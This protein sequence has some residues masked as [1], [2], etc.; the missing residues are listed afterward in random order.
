M[1]ML[2]KDNEDREK[3]ITRMNYLL[4]SDSSSSSDSSSDSTSSS[5]SAS[6]YNIKEI[7]HFTLA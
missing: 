5:S 3:K 6:S 1:K 7:G 2:Q 4:T